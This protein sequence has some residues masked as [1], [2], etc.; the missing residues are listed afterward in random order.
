MR[1]DTPMFLITQKRNE[2]AKNAIKLMFNKDDDHEK[3][4]KYMQRNTSKETDKVSFKSALCEERYSR[5]TFIT[6]TC[7][8]VLF[9]NGIY[10]I[11]S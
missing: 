5:G 3:I 10:P 1:Y 7:A 9:F 8:L 2:E 6:M 4:F 11:T